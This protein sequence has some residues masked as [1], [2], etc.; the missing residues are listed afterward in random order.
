MENL[1]HLTTINAIY[2]DAKESM[3]AEGFNNIYHLDVFITKSEDLL[4]KY[5]QI[6]LVNGVEPKFFEG[7]ITLK[8]FGGLELNFIRFHLANNEKLIKELIL[9]K[10]LDYCDE[11]LMFRY[12]Y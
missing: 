4:I 5:N 12:I 1:S 3:E 11:S 6:W 10:F 8:D 9:N 2:M 7:E